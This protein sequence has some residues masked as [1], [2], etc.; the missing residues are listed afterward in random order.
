MVSALPTAVGV[1]VWKGMGFY[2]VILTAGILHVP[3]ELS[4]AALVDGA[5]KLQRAWRITLPLLGA[6]HGPDYRIADHQWRARVYLA[7]Y[8]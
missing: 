3:K 6:Y 8:S 1:S 5:N 7:L 4:E 2:V